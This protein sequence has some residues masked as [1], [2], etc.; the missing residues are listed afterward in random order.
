MLLALTLTAFAHL[1]LHW[2]HANSQAPAFSLSAHAVV[3]HLFLIFISNR[4]SHICPVRCSRMLLPYLYQWRPKPE[5]MGV[6]LVLEQD[7]FYFFECLWQNVSFFVRRW[8]L[9]REGSTRFSWTR[10]P[11]TLGGLVVYPTIQNGSPN[12]R[13]SQESQKRTSTLDP[14]PSWCHPPPGPWSSMQT[15]MTKS[16]GTKPHVPTSLAWSRSLVDLVPVLVRLPP[17]REGKT[18]DSEDQL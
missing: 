8:E 6:Y 17:W 10:M 5:V 15:R 1:R 13:A 2:G 3:H 4:M 18:A 14:I 11:S 7:Y 12:L 9:E 16:A